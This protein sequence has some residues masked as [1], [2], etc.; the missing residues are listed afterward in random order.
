MVKFFRNILAKFVAYYKGIKL[1][2]KKNPRKGRC[3]CCGR[4]GRTQIHHWV[5]LEPKEK[6]KK[7][8]RLALKGTSELCPLCHKWADLLVAW[9]REEAGLDI[10]YCFDNE[11]VFS[12]LAIEFKHIVPRLLELRRKAL[13]QL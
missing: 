13:E 8:P 6:V 4:R 11:I 5:Y 9:L 1:R 7:N 3:E 10:S 12:Q 2:F